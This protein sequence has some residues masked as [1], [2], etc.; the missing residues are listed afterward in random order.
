MLSRLWEEHSL[1]PRFPEFPFMVKGIVSLVFLLLI[2]TLTSPP[3]CCPL[4]Q[5]LEVAAPEKSV[6]IAAWKQWMEEHVAATGA[7]PPGNA[8]G[9][10]TWTTRKAKRSGK[11]EIRL[12]PGRN[13][14]LTVPL[15]EVTL[16]SPPPCH[17][18]RLLLACLSLPSRKGEAGH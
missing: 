5:L 16:S 15:T 18:S 7:P 6:L 14:Q 10:A 13:T 1:L 11:P 9:N 2:P 4:P 3:L 17:S 8:S 12:T